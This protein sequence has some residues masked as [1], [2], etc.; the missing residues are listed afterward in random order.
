MSSLRCRRFNN[1][2]IIPAALC[3]SPLS[4][5]EDML[6]QNSTVYGTAYSVHSELH[7]RVA[8][9]IRRCEIFVNALDDRCCATIR[10][11]RYNGQGMIKDTLIPLP[12]RFWKM[13][14]SAERNSE[15]RRNS[16]YI[17]QFEYRV[18]THMLRID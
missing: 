2:H 8:G 10:Y 12:Y 5:N 14:W 7:Q 13:W 18:A 6:Q 16:I 3:R 9:T 1:I 17:C 11:H 15:A 4:L